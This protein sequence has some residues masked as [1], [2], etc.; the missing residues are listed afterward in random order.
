MFDSDQHQ[1]YNHLITTP[2]ATFDAVGTCRAFA[3]V[4]AIQGDF[5]SKHYLHKPKTVIT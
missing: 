1:K 3:K 5:I 4:L 2:S